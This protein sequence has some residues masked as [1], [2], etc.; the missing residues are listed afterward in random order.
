MELLWGER[1]NEKLVKTINP[2]NEVEVHFDNPA[3][4]FDTHFLEYDFNRVKSDGRL[5]HLLVTVN[6]VT[7]RVMLAREL[8]ESQEKAQAQLDMLMRILHVDPNSLTTF[9]TD[10]ETSL[11][12]VNAVLHILL[13]SEE[14]AFRTKIDSIYRQIHAVKGESS[15]L[16]LKTV[17]QRAHSFEEALNEIKGRQNISGSDFLPA[18]GRA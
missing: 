11:K 16:G 10:A 15:A 6:D 18:G 2:L 9:L 5:S 8:Q 17:E 4:G 14:A 1:V 7:K 13:F 12:M 3:G